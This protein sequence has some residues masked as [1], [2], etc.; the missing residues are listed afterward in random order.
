MPPDSDELF[1]GLKAEAAEIEG[2]DGPL[3]ELEQGLK[4]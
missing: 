3:R 1:A 4:S 2:D